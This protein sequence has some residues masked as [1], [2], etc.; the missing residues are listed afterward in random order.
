MRPLNDVASSGTQPPVMFLRG[1]PNFTEGKIYK[2]QDPESAIE[3]S[4]KAGRPKIRYTDTRP[5]AEEKGWVKS[6]R[7]CTFNV[8]S[9]LKG[10]RQ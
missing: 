3:P 1:V 10:S 8:F 9:S 4:S 2:R 7:L 6:R 5:D